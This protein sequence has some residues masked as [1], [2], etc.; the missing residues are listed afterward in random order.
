MPDS[1]RL[2]ESTENQPE[3]SERRFGQVLTIAWK[4]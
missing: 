1:Q 4:R 3:S 2:V